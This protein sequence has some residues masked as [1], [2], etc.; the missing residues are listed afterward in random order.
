MSLSSEKETRASLPVSV[1]FLSFGA[2][3]L[4]TATGI[5]GSLVSLVPFWS[6]TWCPMQRFLQLPGAVGRPGGRGACGADQEAA[7][8]VLAPEG[9]PPP[10]YQ[11]LQ[12]E[13]LRWL[14]APEEDT[15]PETSL[16]GPCPEP[17]QGQSQNQPLRYRGAPGTLSQ[18]GKGWEAAILMPD[19]FKAHLFSGRTGPE[20]RV[21]RGR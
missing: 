1:W 16:E 20:F 4:V 2:G 3:H 9:G 18:K 7:S 8:P 11:A 5:P 6:R 15:T 10:W 12:P 21:Q 13:E 14:Q 19:P 17:G